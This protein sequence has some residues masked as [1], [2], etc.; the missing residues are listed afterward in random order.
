MDLF[1][2]NNV[3][4]ATLF[5]PHGGFLRRMRLTEPFP[6]VV[7]IP[8]GFKELAAFVAKS[9]IPEAMKIPMRTFVRKGVYTSE[10][11]M[12]YRER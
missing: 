4:N 11:Q 12:V 9:A 7:Y 1:D 8:R 10:Y 6:S 5:E 3:P 2:E